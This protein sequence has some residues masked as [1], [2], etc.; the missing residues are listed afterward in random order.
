MTYQTVQITD[1]YTELQMA[2]KWSDPPNIYH[3]IPTMEVILTEWL[4]TM[5]KHYIHQKEFAGT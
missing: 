2:I 5:S 1:Q 3:L 4:Q